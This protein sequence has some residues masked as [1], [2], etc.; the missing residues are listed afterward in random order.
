MCRPRSDPKESRAP[1]SREE[2]IK[3]PSEIVSA[4]PGA[5]DLH[6]HISLRLGPDDLAI[7][8]GRE[9]D[10]G[11]PAPTKTRLREVA[12]RIYKARRLRNRIFDQELFG[13]PAWDM[14][15]A[16]YCLPDGGERL[17][18]TALSLTA[19]VPQTTGYR[20]QTVLIER[21][22]VER[23]ADKMD[24][25][26]QFVNLTDKGRTLL[27]KYLTRLCDWDTPFPS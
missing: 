22:L 3:R 16:L 12:L 9:K 5:K 25:R 17:S 14:L 11:A 23:V 20:W 15:L 24:G 21:G 13:E 19:D 26:R 1:L 2:T 6:L 27:E 8:E 10:R 7:L 4:N 18:V